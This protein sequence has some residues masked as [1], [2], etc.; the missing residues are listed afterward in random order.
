[1]TDINVR[2]AVIDVLTVKRIQ[3]ADSE[4]NVRWVRTHPS[5]AHKNRATPPRDSRKNNRHHFTS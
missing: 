3:F 4:A 5:F 2:N 1:M